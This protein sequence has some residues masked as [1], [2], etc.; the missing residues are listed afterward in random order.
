MPIP[1]S[2][3]SLPAEADGYYEARVERRSSTPGLIRRAS[4]PA[5]STGLRFDVPTY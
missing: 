5:P 4:S 2:C 1:P 3:P